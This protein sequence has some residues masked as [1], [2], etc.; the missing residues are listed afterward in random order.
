MYLLPDERSVGL[1][2]K[3]LHCY[4]FYDFIGKFVMLFAYL[5]NLLAFTFRFVKY[6]P[7][8]MYE[9]LSVAYAPDSF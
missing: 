6:E 5:C 9:L 1:V 2:K 3:F 7:K 8:S 4:C